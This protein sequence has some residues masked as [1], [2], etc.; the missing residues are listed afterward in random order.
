MGGGLEWKIDLPERPIVW[1]IGNGA[2]CEKI[3]VLQA[4][5]HLVGIENV[6]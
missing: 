6:S 5:T 4:I 3:K 1:G 2:S